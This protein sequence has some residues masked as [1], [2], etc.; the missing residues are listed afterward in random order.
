MVGSHR[1]CEALTKKGR[2]CRARA[3]RDYCL[4]HDPEDAE[5]VQEARR[6]DGQ[7]RKREATL[8]S[9][10]TLKASPAIEDI[11]RLG[12]VDAYDPLGFDNNINRVRALGYLVRSP[13]P[14][15]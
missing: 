7:R 2:R 1:T 11:R 3:R 14:L 9:A 15:W 8:A 4:F 5:V 13:S 12:E 10:I 6:A